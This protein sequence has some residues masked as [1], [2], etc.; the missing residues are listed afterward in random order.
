MVHGV[1]SLVNIMA[2]PAVELVI[3]RV[4]GTDASGIIRCSSAR[5]RLM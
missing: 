4:H 2:F 3:I 1:A 5:A